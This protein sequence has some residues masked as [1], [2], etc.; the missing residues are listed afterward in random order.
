MLKL[1]WL[2]PI[3]PLFGVAINGLF[4]NRL[5]RRAVGLIGCGVVLAALVV[6]AG[7]VIELSRLPEDARY[8]ETSL[9]TWIPMGPVGGAGTTAVIPW[10]FA[11]DPLSAIMI[12][13]VTGVGFL[14]HVYSVG[15]MEH[16]DGFA[17]FF[18]YLNLFMSMMLTLVLGSNLLVT[19]V[20]WEGVGLCSYLL[21]G[22]FYDRP[23][24]T[25][26]GLTCADAGRKAFLVNRIGDFAFVIGMLYLITT[27]GTLDY[28]AVS[29][30][31]GAGGDGNHA[32]LV[33]VGILLFIGACGK[34]AQIPL[35]VWLPDAMAGPTPVSALIHAATM[36]TAGVY[37]VVRMSAL[38]VHAPEA[39]AVI[40]VVGAGTAI[41][42]A[43]MGI[44]ATDI[45]KVLAYST[46]SQL[47]Y[48]FAAVGVGA[49]TAAIFHLMTHAFFK[50]LLFL[51][52]GSVI[53]G[54]NGE[55]DITKMGGLKSKLPVTFL[56]FMTATLAI[57]GIFP[58]AGFFSKDEILWG[59]WSSGNKLVW[60]VLALSAGL[61]AF[62]MFRLTF[63]VFY[64][65][66]R[67]DHHTF[68]HA[69]E[70]PKAMT[71]PLMILAGLSVVGG[72]IGIP[73]V[74]GTTFFG[75][76]VNMFH[77]W[78]AP[79]IASS[80]GAGGGAAEHGASLE[81]GL[82]GLALGIALAG[83][84][85]AFVIYRQ[86]E[87]MAAAIART[88]RP[89]YATWRNLYWVDEF[90]EA[91]VLKPFYAIA[92]FFAGFDRFVIDGIVNATGIVADITGQLLKLFQ[93]GYVRNYALVL[94]MGVVAI[95]VYLATV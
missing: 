85:V 42:A 13:V 39:M 81:F 79:A 14:I 1:I 59:A 4:G 5:S 60:G 11:L 16:E 76:D 55:Q 66:Y 34:S 32:L 57:A 31:I 38:Y 18:V 69:H 73:A 36:V 7:A 71:V 68:D 33:A 47:G 6:S 26:T 62:Y 86:R 3:L 51:G 17:R 44:T 2:I 46:V 74:L 88:F 72:W 83:I 24:D 49:W 78:L 25:R 50:A 19:F 95:L 10:G 70:S 61:T 75:H 92:R 63:L 48:M 15:Y 84:A 28:R 93:T 89:V 77:H 30:A 53:H 40:A 52:A 94:L 54:Q 56:T 21:I 58:L 67:G 82:M 37:M 8:F 87:G 80:H 91:T 35:Y 23:F 22:F 29:A 90:Y 41:F 43:T 64:G 12:L 9:G 65:K 45:K 20:G 27:F